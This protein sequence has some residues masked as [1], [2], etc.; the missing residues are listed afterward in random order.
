LGIE[1]NP[2]YAE[3]AE[4]RIANAR[5]ERHDEVMPDAA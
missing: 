5:K 1:L 2:A 3:L 4:E